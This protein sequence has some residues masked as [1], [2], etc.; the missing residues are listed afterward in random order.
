M[1][2][3]MMEIYNEEIKDLLCKSRKAAEG[4][5][6]NIV[7]NGDGTTTVSDMTVIDV[8]STEKVCLTIARARAHTHTH[9]HTLRFMCNGCIGEKGTGAIQASQPRA[10]PLSGSRVCGALQ[11]SA[12]HARA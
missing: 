11:S 9:T 8:S 6:H 7:H 4:K 10:V 2:A 12:M 3:S 1:Q 5:K